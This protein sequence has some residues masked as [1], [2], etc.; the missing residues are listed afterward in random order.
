MNPI[1]KKRLLDYGGVVLAVA[2]GVLMLTGQQTTA[3]DLPVMQTDAVGAAHIVIDPGH[4][5]FDGGAVSTSGTTEAPLNLAVAKLT[6]KALREGGFT[7]SLTR[8]TEEALGKNKREDMQA[9]REALN[10]EGVSAVVSIH[11]NKFGDPAISG[12]MVYYMEGSA[13][14]ERLGTCVVE[15]L[16]SV[17]G[18]RERPANPGD[19]FVIR[20]SAAPA[21]IVECGFLSN[22]QEAEKLLDPAYQALLAKGISAGIAAYF[23]LPAGN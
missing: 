8:E 4:G 15:A 19:Y 22:T 18:H 20:E 7:V 2:V 1:W 3:A 16:C 23:S 11:M 14:G 10:A 13:E 12:P 6:A 5:G 9:R 21:V 17:I